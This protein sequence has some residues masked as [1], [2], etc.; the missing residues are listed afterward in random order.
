MDHETRLVA[1][2]LHVDQKKFLGDNARS[3]RQVARRAM[4][5]RAACWP[6]QYCIFIIRHFCVL[7][8]RLVEPLTTVGLY[9]SQEALRDLGLSTA[10]MGSMAG[11]SIPANDE[12]EAVTTPGERQM[13]AGKL[14]S[15]SL[16]ER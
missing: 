6:H 15:S 13:G 14:G 4:R 9:V 12:L 7:R 16:T 1:L 8:K 10:A 5:Y 3:P 2:V 11:V